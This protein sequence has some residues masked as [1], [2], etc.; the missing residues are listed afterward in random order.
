[1]GKINQIEGL[2]QKRCL[3]SPWIG[4]GS[5]FAFVR[6]AATHVLNFIGIEVGPTRLNHFECRCSKPD[7][8]FHLYSVY[9][10]LTQLNQFQFPLFLPDQFK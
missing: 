1:M 6:N 4:A 5:A 3:K 7:Y 9:D 2:H 10:G 8:F